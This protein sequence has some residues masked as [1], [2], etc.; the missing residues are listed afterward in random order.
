MSYPSKEELEADCRLEGRISIFYQKPGSKD[1]AQALAAEIGGVE[2][3]Q[4]Y[5][6]QM[7]KKNKAIRPINSSWWSFVESFSLVFAEKAVGDCYLVAR[8]PQEETR[9]ETKR[10]TKKER[11]IWEN[12][13]LPALMRNVN[14]TSITCVHYEDFNL[15]T[16]IYSRP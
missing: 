11:S 2:I 10:E 12:V 14:V 15:R 1:I 16:I 3:S 6:T 13:E 5:S 7:L 9:K 8:V 4:A